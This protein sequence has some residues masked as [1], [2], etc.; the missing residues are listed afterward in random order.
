MIS[1]VQ[2]KKKLIKWCGENV[3]NKSE[4]NNKSIKKLSDGSI[5]YLTIQLNDT[6]Y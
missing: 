3:V 1:G 2:K 6:K 5:D 4:C